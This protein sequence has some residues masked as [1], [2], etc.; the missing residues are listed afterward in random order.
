MA[1]CASGADV[2]HGL[3]AVCTVSSIPDGASTSAGGAYLQS[4]VLSLKGLRIERAHHAAALLALGKP[5]IL[6]WAMLGS[7]GG[8][9]TALPTVNIRRPAAMRAP[10][11]MH[12]AADKVSVRIV[13]VITFIDHRTAAYRTIGRRLD[14]AGAGK[15]FRYLGN[16]H[17]GFIYRNGIPH[18]KIQF[19]HNADVMQ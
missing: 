8:Q 4:A 12:P 6:S 2:F 14:P 17:I 13:G 3:L 5:K 15:V 7:E 1:S 9:N 10:D 19:F 18:R 11:D 16:N